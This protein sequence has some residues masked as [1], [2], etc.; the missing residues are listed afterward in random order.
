MKKVTAVLICIMLVLSLGITGFAEDAGDAV[1]SSSAQ[2]G[3]SEEP[4]DGDLTPGQS[5]EAQFSVSPEEDTALPNA[6]TEPEASG[7]PV[8]G[9]GAD[10]EEKKD[11]NAEPSGLPAE[12]SA[13]ALLLGSSAAVSDWEELKQA[14]ESGVGGTFELPETLEA[15]N[16]ITIPQGTEVVLAANGAG[17]HISRQNIKTGEF[18]V[19]SGAKLTLQG[20]FV[21]SHETNLN[22]ANFIRVEEGG[23]LTL[24]A[25]LEAQA[26]NTEYGTQNTDRNG[27]YIKS[28]IDCSGKLTMSAGSVVT[29]W[30]QNKQADRHNVNYDPGAAVKISG[31]N[32]SFIMNG[33]SITGNT[34]TNV[35][36]SMV[37]SSV[38][39]LDGAAFLMNDGEISGNGKGASESGRRDNSTLGG[40]VYV[41]GSKFTMNGGSISDNEGRNG[42]GVYLT[43][44]AEFVMTGGSITG[45]TLCSRNTTASGGGVYVGSGC[46]FRMESA[47]ANFPASVSDNT[48]YTENDEYSYHQY[49]GGGVYVDGTFIMKDAQINGNRAVT[50]SGNGGGGIYNRGE[51]EIEGGEISGNMAFY[52]LDHTGYYSY[53]GGVYS[54]SGSSFAAAGT[55]IAGNTA[56]HGGGIYGTRASVSLTDCVIEGNTATMANADSYGGGALLTTGSTLNISNTV[57]QKN[58]SK[59]YG[60]GLHIQSMSGVTVLGQG[61]TVSENTAGIAGGGLMNVG[62]ETEIAGAVITGNSAPDGAGAANMASGTLRMTGGTITENTAA[63]TGGGVANSNG[64][65]TMTGGAIYN[66]QAGDA[67]ADVGS[68][69]GGNTVFTLPEASS[70]G[71]PGVEKWFEDGSLDGSVPRYEGHETEVPSYVSFSGS[72]E[73]HLLTLGPVSLEQAWYYEVYYEYIDPDTNEKDWM[74]YEKG[75]GGWALPGDTVSISHLTF[76][77][78]ELGWEDITGSQPEIL[79]VHYVY[80]ENYG[81][82]RLSATAAEATEENPLKIYYRAALHNVIY[83]YEGDVPQGAAAVLPE[84]EAAPYYSRVTVAQAPSL[85]GYEFSGWIVKSPDYTEVE[86]SSFIMPNENVTLVGSWSEVETPDTGQTV[87]LTPQNM[88]AYTGGDSISGDTFPTVRYQIEAEDEVEL[89]KLTF[90]VDGAEYTLENGTESGDIVILPWLDAGFTLKESASMRSLVRSGGE[91]AENDAVAGEYEITVNTEGLS[92]SSSDGNSVDIQTGSGTL[93]VRNV[94][95]PEGVIEKEADITKP[96]TALEEEINTQDGIGAALIPAG[97]VYYTN[98]REELGVLGS[99]ISGMPQ[100]SLLFDDLIPGENG[101]DTKQLLID[102]AAKDGFVLTNENSEFKYLDLVNENDG[103][104]WVSANDG[105]DI[106]IY[107]PCPEGVNENGFTAQVLHFKGLHREYR[108]DMENQVEQAEI[109]VINAEISDGNVV[110][111]LTGNQTSGSFSPFAVYWKEKVPE[112]G[113]GS[114][115]VSLT[116]SGN[117]AEPNREFGFTVTLNDSGISGTYGDMTFINGVAS[118]ALKG[119]E[120]ILAVGLPEGTAYEVTQENAEGYSVRSSGTVGII[121]AGGVARADYENHKELQET[122][123]GAGTGTG[124]TPADGLDGA[125]QT[126]DETSV[127]QYVLAA[128]AGMAALISAVRKL[129]KTAH[130]EK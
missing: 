71:L 100:I 36:N 8:P 110:F 32:A 101:E 86:N 68:Y 55:T 88:I 50:T 70:C 108:G 80:D 28:F 56:M 73:D 81:F 121:A 24:E 30:T 112:T 66:N 60:G 12:S 13:N 67:G 4:A 104:A 114:L 125:P 117:G 25:R 95:D 106:T 75:Q 27:E 65:F 78:E 92:V 77:G 79:G 2:M 82:H 38:Q 44:G 84:T 26:D 49:H 105:A 83:Q 98:G 58:S 76:D 46:T 72:T 54:A 10:G 122:A 45:N 16:V 115:S 116:L 69:G 128:A 43:S 6:G 74:E 33:G 94:S 22:G 90:E 118:F 64:T 37:T 40:G 29:G 7:P 48:L 53:G 19:S 5:P 89:S 119:G 14:I 109:E 61:V 23:E 99:S 20:S 102:R 34:N 1:P 52:D 113:T 97:T 9:D 47:D 120:S 96:V 62:T 107:W 17:S 130:Q 11:G 124:Q 63:S 18:I 87:V 129:K 127:L 91:M 35:T 103:N 111:H 126:G 31:A 39:I 15:G 3:Q 51:V 41:S 93:T 21:V 85:K 123:G 57:V 59:S 42:A